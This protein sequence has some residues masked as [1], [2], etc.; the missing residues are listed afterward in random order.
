MKQRTSLAFLLSLSTLLCLWFT[1]SGERW[2]A[3]LENTSMYRVHLINF[4]SKN[5]SW[6][7]WVLWSDE[8]RMNMLDGCHHVYLDMGTNT[9]VQIR[10][11]ILV[12]WVY[13]N[14]GSSLYCSI[15]YPFPRDDMQWSSYSPKRQKIYFT[16]WQHSRATKIC[17]GV[18]DNHSLVFF[19][20]RKLYEPH[21]F[22]NASVLKIFQKHFGNTLHR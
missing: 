14:K 17:N 10:F 22:P 6:L 13:T 3:E 2:L 18:K 15:G 1:T 4:G 7:P 20:F 21:L 12:S 19:F 11:N 16:N 9:G 8:E 5:L